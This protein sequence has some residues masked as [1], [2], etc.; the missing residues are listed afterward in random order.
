MLSALIVLRFLWLRTSAW[1]NRSF[2]VSST[3]TNLFASSIKSWATRQSIRIILSYSSSRNELDNKTEFVPFISSPSGF[4]TSS[5]NFSWFRLM[6]SSAR[7]TAVAFQIFSRHTAAGAYPCFCALRYHLIASTW[8]FS[9]PNP[10][11]NPYPT[12]YWI[13]AVLWLDFWARVNA[14]A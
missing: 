8:F 13:T 7:R 5:Q 9:Q 10:F 6:F 2:S 4:L 11:S 1:A 14:L 12:I 3:E